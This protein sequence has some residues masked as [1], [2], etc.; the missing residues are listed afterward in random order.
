M[1]DD[2]PYSY[3]DRVRYGDLDTNRHLNNV[4]VHQFF[5]SARVAYMR[6]LFPELDPLGREDSAFGMIF[7]ETHVRF[8][9][10]GLYEDDLRTHVRV[11][12]LKR[13]S[14]RLGFR[15]TCEDDGRVVAEG[16][17]TLVGYDYASGRA[18]AL[19]EYVAERLRPPA[20]G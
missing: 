4:A 15:I 6:A 12:E 10:P 18:M 7:A 13:S 8:R 16:W 1:T 17:G 3:L 5:E 9:S 11:E 19:P 2:W 14:V 20:G